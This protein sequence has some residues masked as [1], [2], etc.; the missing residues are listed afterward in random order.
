MSAQF[1]AQ[2][3]PGTVLMHNYF[4]PKNLTIYRVAKETGI[5]KKAMT[6]VLCGR[7][8]LPVKDA[9]LLARYFGE[10]DD[11]FADLQLRHDL[12]REQE[13]LTNR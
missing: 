6:R 13:Y 4:I 3:H 10:A 7:E 8:S 9:V 1:T 11:F 5:D 12:R 2:D